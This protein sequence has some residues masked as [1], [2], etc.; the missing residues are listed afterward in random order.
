MNLVEKIGLPFL[1]SLNINF[2]HMLELAPPY[3]QVGVLQLQGAL[4]D[5]DPQKAE[6]HLKTFLFSENVKPPRKKK[7]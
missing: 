6:K 1:S 2:P 3:I 4:E 5:G 7:H